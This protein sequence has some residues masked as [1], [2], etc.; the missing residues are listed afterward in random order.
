MWTFCRKTQKHTVWTL[1]RLL[2]CCCVDVDSSGVCL[3][4]VCISEDPGKEPEHMVFIK[5][6]IVESR[7]DYMG[8]SILMARVSDL[9]V[10]V[11][12]EWHVDTGA[13]KQEER[14]HS[15]ATSRSP[16][17]L[18][19][20][21]LSIKFLLLYVLNLDIGL[22]LGFFLWVVYLSEQKLPRLLQHQTTGRRWVEFCWLTPNA[23]GGG[24]SHSRNFRQ[25]CDLR[26]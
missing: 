9:A 14:R 21:I 11:N 2:Y 15:I 26:S 10:K 3:C 17:Q 20:S 19:H 22:G 4:V 6:H 12:D 5:L 24:K 8:S 13:S 18:E 1:L 16:V 7:L 25:K 23:R